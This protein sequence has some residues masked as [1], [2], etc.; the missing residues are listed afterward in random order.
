MDSEDLDEVHTEVSGEEEDEEVEE[1][2]GERASQP[3]QQDPEPQ[4]AAGEPPAE[5]APVAQPTAPAG[6]VSATSAAVPRQLCRAVPIH[7]EHGS[8]RP[9]LIALV[10]PGLSTCVVITQ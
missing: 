7:Q 8:G 4:S 5:A 6:Q 3:P 10:H 1:E 2:G 9:L